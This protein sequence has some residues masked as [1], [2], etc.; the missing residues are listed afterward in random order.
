MPLER[1]TSDTEVRNFIQMACI[2]RAIEN[3]VVES[4]EEWAETYAAI[5]SVVFD[6][7]NKND[8]LMQVYRYG[9]SAEKAEWFARLCVDLKIDK[10]PPERGSQ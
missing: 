6:R 9:T 10:E 4:I 3:R 7:L 5:F 2:Q 8:V 1:L